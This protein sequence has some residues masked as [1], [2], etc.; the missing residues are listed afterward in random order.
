MSGTGGASM[1]AW[2]VNGSGEP[3]D[4]S[5]DIGEVEGRA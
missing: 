5:E 2:Q 4:A 3:V 1:R